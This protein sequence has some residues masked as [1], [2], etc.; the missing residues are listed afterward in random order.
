MFDSVRSR[1]F[2]Q[3]FTV[4]GLPEGLWR[5]V[6][7]ID[8][9][10]NGRFAPCDGL[11]AGFDRLY[12]IFE[13]VR[14]SRDSVIDVGAVA[15][16]DGNC[17][18]TPPTG[19][20]GT[21]AVETEM[22]AVGSGRPIRMELYPTFDGGER[23]SFLLFE[24]HW[25]VEDQT[26]V[27]TQEVPPGSY[28][29]RIYLDSNRNGDYSSCEGDI[30]GDR[31]SSQLFS[32]VLEAGQ[33]MDLGHFQLDVEP[34]AVPQSRIE[35]SLTSPEDSE[36]DLTRMRM[37]LSEAGGWSEDRELRGRQVLGLWV[38]DPTLVA[39]GDYSLV[40]YE[41][42]DSN[43]AYESCESGGADR[44]SVEAEVSLDGETPRLT[45]TLALTAKC[46]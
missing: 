21:V 36:P 26:A 18:D 46:R 34:C 44:V 20:R 10:A 2:P 32:V 4:T 38:A 11:P 1:P 19:L 41:D 23:L 13:E 43:G 27:F 42:H 45:T 30:Y 39:P 9:D 29:A 40:V 12:S 17:G 33:L 7:F 25:T 35:L 8:R 16:A 24:N 37:V 5:V 15:L 3:N 14:V 31:A 22:G 28:Q 6:F